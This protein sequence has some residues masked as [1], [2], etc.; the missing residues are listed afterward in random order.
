M[1]DSTADVPASK[2]KTGVFIGSQGLRAGWGILLFILVFSAVAFAFVM[3]MHFVLHM[4]GPKQTDVLDAR[5]TLI[6]EGVQAGLFLVATVITALIE[7]RSLAKLGFGLN[8]AVMRFVTGT[9]VG[10][11]AMGVLIGL[12][13]LCHAIT[14]GAPLL[15][16]ADIWRSG[17]MWLAAF[18][19]VGLSEELAFRTYLQQTLTRGLNFRWALVILS[20]LFAAAHIGNGGENPIGLANVVVA[21]VILALSVWRT[22][23]IWW[24]VGFHM[25]WDWAQSFLFGVADSGHPAVG[26]YMVS[27]PMGADWLSGGSVGPE[28]SLLATIVMVIVGILIWVTMRKQD[29]KLDGKW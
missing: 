9:I 11:V 7:R 18:L 22:G 20:V 24:A 26:S 28:G 2:P 27:K 16:G 29:V 25:A 5:N 12:L 4:H 1:T 14:L 10:L 6:L 15:H 19:F 23:T 13:Y 8:N 17:G 21:G 3:T